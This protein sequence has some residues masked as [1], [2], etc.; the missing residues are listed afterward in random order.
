[1]NKLNENAEVNDLTRLENRSRLTMDKLSAGAGIIGLLGFIGLFL[2]AALFFITEN[3]FVSM[4][5]MSLG[6]MVYVTGKDIVKIF[7]SS[8]TVF[9]STKHLIEKAAFLQ[10][11]LPAIKKILKVTGNSQVLNEEGAEGDE[12][13]Y[14][15]AAED[16]MVVVLPQNALSQDISNLLMQGQDEKYAEFVAHSYYVDCHELYEFTHDNLDFVA[17]AMPLF[18]LIGTII[19]LIAMFDSLGANVTVETLAPQ[20]ALALKT[21]LYGA[22]FSSLYKII[23]SRFEQRT[24]ALEYDYETFCY[25][26][27]VIF[28]SKTRVEVKQ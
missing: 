3:Y 7:L 27:D 14:V 4:G 13:G 9:F 24:K 19:G 5:T 2:V 21:T 25:G 8:F 6:L 11:N 15:A 26:L 12:G 17:D 23:G 1:M 16:D 28:Q 10:E 20:L 22:I 18:G